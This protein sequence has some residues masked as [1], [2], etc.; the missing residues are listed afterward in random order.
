ML[1]GILSIQNGDNPR[2]TM[3]KMMAFL[4]QSSRLTLKLNA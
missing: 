1:Q 4:P 2:T 3:D